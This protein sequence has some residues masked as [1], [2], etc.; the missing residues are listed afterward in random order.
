MVPIHRPAKPRSIVRSRGEILGDSAGVVETEHFK[1]DCGTPSD[2]D[3][4]PE[5]FGLQHVM[6]GVVV[7]LAEQDEI[8]AGQ[9]FDQTLPSDESGGGDLPNTTGERMISAQR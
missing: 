5:H 2:G 3:Q 8:S 6:V 4:A 9:T 7:P 1:T